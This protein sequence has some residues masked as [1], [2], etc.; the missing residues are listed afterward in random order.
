ME[1][2][3]HFIGMPLIEFDRDKEEK[4]VSEYLSQ[5]GFVPKGVSVFLF[6]SD[7]F[8]QHGGIDKEWEATT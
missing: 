4:G 2:S 8:N 6:H 7:I 1:K 5:M 3:N